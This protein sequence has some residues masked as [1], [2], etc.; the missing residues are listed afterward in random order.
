VQ[1]LDL[2][3]SDSLTEIL[4]IAHKSWLHSLQVLKIQ[5]ITIERAQQ[6]IIEMQLVSV[7]VSMV[8]ALGSIRL[9]PGVS[10]RLNSISALSRHSNVH[11]L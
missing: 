5:E 4:L 1:V 6:A 9:T 2:G 10:S 7:Y 3:R 8:H 11:H